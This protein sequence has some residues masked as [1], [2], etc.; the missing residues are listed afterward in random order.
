MEK[1]KSKRITT[2]L[3]VNIARRDLVDGVMKYAIRITK[4]YDKTKQASIQKRYNEFLQLNTDLAQNGFLHLPVFPPKS[5]FANDDDLN[6]RQAALET[7]LKA[8]IDR[9]DTRNSKWIQ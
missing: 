5:F 7:Y 6:K 3:Q 4:L 2:A 8:L 9:K 1:T